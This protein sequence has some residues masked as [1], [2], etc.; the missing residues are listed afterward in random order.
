[1]RETT[2]LSKQGRKNK[3]PKQRA[4]SESSGIEFNKIFFLNQYV[5]CTL[6][7]AA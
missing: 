4:F 3:N 2:K 1:M 5:H 7:D 6:H